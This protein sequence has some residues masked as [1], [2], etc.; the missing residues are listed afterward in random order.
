MF[1]CQKVELKNVGC[2]HSCIPNLASALPPAP[3][4]CL[5]TSSIR[6]AKSALKPDQTKHIDPQV[7]LEFRVKMNGCKV[8]KIHPTSV[9]THQPPS[10]KIL[11]DEED[12]GN[13]SLKGIRKANSISYE[14]FSVNDD[15]P[16]FLHAP[17]LNR[18]QQEHMFYSN[19]LFREE[20]RNSLRLGNSAGMPPELVYSNACYKNDKYL[21]P[22]PYLVRQNV[23]GTHVLYG[24][25]GYAPTPRVECDVVSIRPSQ[26]I[27]YATGPSTATYRHITYS[28]T[29]LLN[30]TLSRDLSRDDS[31][32]CGSY[33]AV[34]HFEYPVVAGSTPI[35]K[36]TAC[37]L[38]ENSSDYS[39]SRN[40]APTQNAT[41]AGKVYPHP[42]ANCTL[43]IPSKRQKK[44]SPVEKEKLKKSKSI[45]IIEEAQDL[46]LRSV[47]CPTAES[48]RAITDSLTYHS[49]HRAHPAHYCSGGYEKDPR[50]SYAETDS[51]LSFNIYSGR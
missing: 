34:S 3:K 31:S 9:M 48:P 6:S 4:K 26:D 10:S 21:P 24:P 5:P 12:D 30:S 13:L 28:Q 25:V 39:V 44:L 15:T 16:S 14:H 7:P 18:V 42:L 51:D 2:S 38:P 27:G 20:Q 22:T 45:S 32:I 23:D 36:S 41:P 37:R 49:Y 33:H 47:S 19:L 17:Y 29:D 43:S 40:H 35:P 50:L 8:E 11:S 1:K 46:V